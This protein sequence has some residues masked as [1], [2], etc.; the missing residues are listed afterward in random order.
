MKEDI[1]DIREDLLNYE[2]FE[3]RKD[4]R[5]Y[6]KAAFL[7]LLVVLL[8]IYIGNMLFGD[9]SLEMMLSLEQKRDKLQ[10]ITDELK[11]ENAKLQRKYFE[12][13][14]IEAVDGR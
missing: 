2:E 3:K 9:N 14:Q 10:K 6:F 8:G 13:K 4:S 1:S 11:K 7:F 12:L 5:L